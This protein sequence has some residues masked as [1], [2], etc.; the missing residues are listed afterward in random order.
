MGQC[1][2]KVHNK[3]SDPSRVTADLNL[4]QMSFK[5]LLEL[6]AKLRQQT[7]SKE[8]VAFYEFVHQFVETKFETYMNTPCDIKK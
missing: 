6:D 1:Q 4:E 7:K 5:D 8:I 3:C 2:Y